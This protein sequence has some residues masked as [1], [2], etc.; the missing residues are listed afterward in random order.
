MTVRLIALYASKVFSIAGT[1]SGM[2]A[3]EDS[4][5][6][7]HDVDLGMVACALREGCFDLVATSAA[8]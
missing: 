7:K 5:N 8:Y 4:P 1:M 2:N 3:G 6:V